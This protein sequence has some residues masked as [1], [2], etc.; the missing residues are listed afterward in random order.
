MAF[1]A[2]VRI[3]CN[4]EA[5]CQKNGR[6]IFWGRFAWRNDFIVPCN[7][8]L[9]EWQNDE[10]WACVFTEIIWQFQLFLTPW[11]SQIK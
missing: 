1:L 11:K 8:S 6:E 7:F 9:T 10:Q 4:F 3:S 5:G 2:S